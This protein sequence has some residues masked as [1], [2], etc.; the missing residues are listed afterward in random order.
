[1]R[2]NNQTPHDS[3][4]R[5][6]RFQAS[7]LLRRTLLKRKRD[8]GVAKTDQWLCKWRTGKQLA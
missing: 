8:A 5:S 1:M 7:L 4:A 3:F 2:S 6:A